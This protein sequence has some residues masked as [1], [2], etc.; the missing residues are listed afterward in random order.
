VYEAVSVVDVAECFAL[1]DVETTEAF[2]AVGDRLAA[3][4][5]RWK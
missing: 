4:L 2:A 3:M 1:V 5:Y